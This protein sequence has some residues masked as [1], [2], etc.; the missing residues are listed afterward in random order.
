[1]GC[2]YTSIAADELKRPATDGAHTVD[3]DPADRQM[4]GPRI[5]IRVPRRDRLPMHANE[6]LFRP[7]LRK[8]RTKSHHVA[9]AALCRIPALSLFVLWIAC[10]GQ[11]EPFRG[12]GPPEAFLGGSEYPYFGAETP[13]NLRFF[14]EHPERLAK[15]RGQRQMLDLVRGR[16]REAARYA[17][18]LLAVD[19]ADQESLFNLA[20]ARAQVGQLDRALEATRLAEEAG[21]PFE[22]F[23]AGPRDLLKPLT[24]YEPFRQ[25][26]LRRDIRLI[27]GPM[28]GSVTG[29]GARFWVRTANEA[30]VQVV[31][32]VENGD[33]GT[34]DPEIRSESVRSTAAADFTAIVALE[35]LDPRTRYRYDVLIDGRPEMGPGYPSFATF[36]ERGGPSRFAVGF[37]GGA[38]YVVHNERMWDVIRSR[39]PHAFL[40][41]GDNVYIDLPEQPGGMHHY[42]YYRRQS[43]AEFRRLVASTAVYAIWDDHDCAT[44]DVWMGP[45]KD[46]PAW[47]MPLLR[48]FRQNWVNPGYGSE[49]WPATWFEFSIGDVDFFM[50]DGRFYRTNP[51]GESPTMLGPA[52]KQ[53]LLDRVKQSAATFKVLVSPV[54]WSFDTKGDAVDTWNGF[55]RERAEIFDF[56]AQN[57]IEGVFLVSADRHRS[58]ARRIDRPNGYPLF[59]FE[60]SRLTN[61]A[62]HDLVPGALF[63]YNEKQSFGLLS[64]DT[65]RADPTVSF[66]IVS[67]D[68][69]VRGEISLQRSELAH[70]VR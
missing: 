32:A 37:G 52:Q 39:D 9:M 51:F 40:F 47:K 16:P 20:I 46:K 13:W 48:H 60:S 63:G 2:W 25:E 1:M 29:T 41:L 57:R 3:T 30:A 23:L 6:F 64:F 8:L 36:P 58:D 11:Q 17:E 15:R 59:E 10:T 70:P 33:T 66:Q 22:R 53:W 31:A 5:I 4:R 26:A 19:P 42:T 7:T 44:D 24:D 38:G 65:T 62:A 69:K 14:T 35:G 68:G 27:H 43:R 45:Y 12:N 21:L 49:E 61:Q 67:I 56:L 54:P 55:R 18:E 34:L 50:L 28:V